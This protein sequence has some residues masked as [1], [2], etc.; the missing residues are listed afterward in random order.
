MDRLVIVNGRLITPRGVVDNAG[1]VAEGGRITA[2]GGMGGLDAGGAGRVVDAG[3][4]YI[5]PGFVDIHVHGGGGHDFMDGTVEAFLGAAAAHA[6]HGTTTLVPTTLACG[7][8]E[9]LHTFDVFRRAR[10]AR[11]GG[12]NMP[13]LHLEGPYFS[14]E[15]RGAQDPKYILSPS[16]AHARGILEAGSAD[17]LR[18]SMAPE[19][20]GARAL[21]SELSH[22]GI[23]PSIAHTDAF[24]EQI[25]E[26]VEAGFTHFT[27]LYSG[28][29]GVRRIGG[30]RRAGAV[31]AAYIL[32]ATTVEVIAD[33][34]H[35][36]GPLLRM[37]HRC[38]GAGR[39]ALITDAMRAAG[40][41][42]TESTLGSRDNGLPVV[43]DRG[44]AWLPDR[45]AFAGSVATMDRAVRTMVREAG[46]PLVDAV[47]MATETPA[48][49]MGFGTK[50]RLEP[51]MD[52]DIVLFDGDIHVSLAVVGGRAQEAAF[53]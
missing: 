45:S 49:I 14:M 1:V 13:G 29:Q 22:R 3:G 42:C 7:Y 19:L 39:T 18:W 51:G 53:A 15:Q 40:T 31:E 24:F 37:V 41:A 2:A 21:A 30:M 52:A 38:I 35:L 8:G 47:A 16:A 17:I 23:L 27:H 25:E 26:A 43:V 5:A 32:E 10:A 28:M 46:I 6:R 36:P 11:Q 33:G 48:R 9:L 4:R 20:E 12:A 50:G 44:V 34:I